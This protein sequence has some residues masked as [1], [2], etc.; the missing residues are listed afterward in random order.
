VDTALREKRHS[1]Y[2]RTP[3]PQV[4]EDYVNELALLPPARLAEFFE[5]P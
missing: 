3:R 1:W 4:I 5:K 2:E